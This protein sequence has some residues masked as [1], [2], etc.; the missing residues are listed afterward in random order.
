M[1][2]LEYGKVFDCKSKLN[3]AIAQFKG[4]NRDINS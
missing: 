3:F 2:P 1:T 4:I